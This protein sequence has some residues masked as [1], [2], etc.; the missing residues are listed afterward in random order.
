MD[1][2]RAMEAKGI[3]GVHREHLSEALNGRMSPLWARKIEIGLDL[4]KYTLVKMAGTPKSS[5][6][7]KEIEMLGD[8]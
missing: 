6:V 5:A 8:K 1:L 3:T 7:M 2:V 4:P